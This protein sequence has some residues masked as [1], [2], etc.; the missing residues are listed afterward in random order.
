MI[1]AMSGPFEGH[2]FL[3]VKYGSQEIFFVAE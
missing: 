3:P 1:V 2:F